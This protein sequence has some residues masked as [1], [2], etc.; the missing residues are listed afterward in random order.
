[1]DSVAY[2][3]DDL[4]DLPAMERCVLSAAPRNAVL[5]VREQA[6][7]VLD[8][9]AGHGALRELVDRVLAC[10]EATC[11]AITAYLATCGGVAPG[12]LLAAEDESALRPKIGFR[13]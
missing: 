2:L 10:Q 8:L 9:P 7:L 4:L 6:D 5:L 12:N 11:R 13:G 1:L 3:G